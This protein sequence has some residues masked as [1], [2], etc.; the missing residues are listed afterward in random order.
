MDKLFS[1]AGIKDSTHKNKD[2]F[3]PKTPLSLYISSNKLLDE[4]LNNNFTNEINKYNELLINIL[5]LLYYFKIPFIGD[6]WI[7]H[8]KMEKEKERNTLAKSPRKERASK[9]SKFEEESKDLKGLNETIKEIIAILVD[10]F[11]VVKCNRKKK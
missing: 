8:Y 7:E 3:I 4:Y 10:L 1:D 5:S 11:E 2:K 9:I 6:K